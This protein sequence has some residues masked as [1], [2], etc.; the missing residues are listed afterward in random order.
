[1]R[2]MEVIQM[3]NESVSRNPAR[4]PVIVFSGYPA[5][6]INVMDGRKTRGYIHEFL[7]WS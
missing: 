3:A 5:A 7:K 4:F 6:E 2:I 1:M